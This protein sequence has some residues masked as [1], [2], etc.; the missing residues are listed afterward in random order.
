MSR[1]SCPSDRWN[2]EQK[3]NMTENYSI[4]KMFSMETGTNELMGYLWIKIEVENS[5]ECV[6]VSGDYNVLVWY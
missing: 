6:C 3:Y 4:H 2:T 1:C 5:S